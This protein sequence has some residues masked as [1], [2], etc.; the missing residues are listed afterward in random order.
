MP[1]EYVEGV[2]GE[3]ILVQV[4]DGAD[5][6]VFAHDCL[7]NTE[8]GITRSAQTTQQTLP[9][10][11]DPSKP[12]KTIRQVDSTDSIINGAGKLHESSTLFWLQNVG[13]TL[14]IRVRKAGVF[15][16]AGPYILAE[17]AITGTARQLATCTV[18]LEQADEPE[19]TDDGA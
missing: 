15:R 18:R 11:T 16:V 4:G 14:N 19:I 1:D 3:E 10:C 13:K 12:D 5:P 8:R 7:I 2:S 6:E 17:F 9:N